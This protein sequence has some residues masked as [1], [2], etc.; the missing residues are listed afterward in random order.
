[1]DKI[2][3]DTYYQDAST[4]FSILFKFKIISVVYFDS[5]AV[6]IKHCKMWVVFNVV[7]RFGSIYRPP[8]Y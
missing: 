8:K 1:M 4:L 7:N 3:F 5:Q 2:F 6:S